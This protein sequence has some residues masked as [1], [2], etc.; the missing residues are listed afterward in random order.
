MV[1]YAIL[2]ESHSQANGMIEMLAILER[3]FVREK[4]ANGEEFFD[5]F[6]ECFSFRT[7]LY[8][9]TGTVIYHSLDSYLKWK[10]L[11]KDF[12]PL[13]LNQVFTGAINKSIEYYS[14]Y[15]EAQLDLK[16]GEVNYQGAPDVELYTDCR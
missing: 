7:H 14:I 4:D 5:R 13:T 3:D 6:F 8:G 12:M 11:E 1:R 10:E 16:D 9:F 15:S 2:F